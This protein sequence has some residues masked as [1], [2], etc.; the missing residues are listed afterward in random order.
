MKVAVVHTK[1][2]VLS[3]LDL[4]EVISVVDTESKEIE[5]YENPGFERV[6]GGKEIAT[7]TIIRLKVD[8]L[9]VKSG[10]MCPGSYRMSQGRIKYIVSP[11]NELEEF[12]EKIDSLDLT[13][14]LEPEVYAEYE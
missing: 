4:G 9:A 8:A 10:G 2:N 13:D 12:V 3:P 1:D 5:Q 11:F 7:A 6:P 14:E